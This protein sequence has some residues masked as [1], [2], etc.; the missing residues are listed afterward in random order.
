MSNEKVCVI[1]LLTGQ[2][3]AVKETYDEVQSFLGEVMPK[4]FCGLHYFGDGEEFIVSVKH[5][6][7]FENVPK[8]MLQKQTPKLLIPRDN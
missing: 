4:G 6:T 7:H 2:K 5:I 8:D 3:L 1:Y